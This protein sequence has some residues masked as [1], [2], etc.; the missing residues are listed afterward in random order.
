MVNRALDNS[1]VCQNNIG[2]RQECQNDK[3]NCRQISFNHTDDNNKLIENKQVKAKDRSKRRSKS[4]KRDFKTT[5]LIDQITRDC[6]DRISESNSLE[7]C[8]KRRFHTPC[9]DGSEQG[10]AYSPNK[11]PTGDGHS[12]T[13]IG[14]S[15]SNEFNSNV[16]LEFSNKTVGSKTAQIRSDV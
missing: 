1:T 8:A 13:P 2:N 9:K 5:S 12:D 7:Q 11:K 16:K 3:G 14:I 10:T 6:G 15:S 4:E